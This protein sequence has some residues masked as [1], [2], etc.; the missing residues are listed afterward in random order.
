M[1]VLNWSTRLSL[2]SAF[3]AIFFAYESSAD[4]H[5]NLQPLAKSGQV[6]VTYRGDCPSEA[7]DGVI[8]QI[9][10]IISY[11]RKNSPVLYSSSPGIWADGKVGAVDLHDSKESME[12]AFAWQASDETWSSSYAKIAASCETTVEE[13]EVVMLI[14]R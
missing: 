3:V 8:E 11:E 10:T 4:H 2:L 13:F 9:K 5:K 12:E 1:K 6:I 7:V 14:A